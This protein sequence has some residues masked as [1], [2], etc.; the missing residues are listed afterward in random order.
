MRGVTEQVESGLDSSG[1]GGGEIHVCGD[2]LKSYQGERIGVRALAIVTHERAGR[3][4]GV[5]ELGARKTVVEQ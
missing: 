1:C 5:I 2:V 3:A 4:V